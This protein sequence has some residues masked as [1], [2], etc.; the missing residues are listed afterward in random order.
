MILLIDNYDSFVHNLAR[1]FR[2]L[3]TTAHVVR[4]DAVDLPTIRKLQPHAIV[5]SPGPCTPTQA[6]CSLEVVRELGGEVPILGVCLGHQAIGAA[7]GGKIVP[8]PEPM[9]GRTS[10]IEHD[11][12]GLFAG[13]PSPLNVGRYHSLVIEPG[14]LPKQLEVT[15]RTVDGVIMAV[16]HRVLPIWGVQFHPESILTE[17]GYALLA[18]FLRMAGIEPALLAAKTDEHPPA[19]IE[20]VLPSRPVTF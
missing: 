3:G 13:L 20:Y 5:L 8:A 7:L 17:G 10:L 12:A 16:A 2:R 4:N 15:A 11:G 18:N 19:A 1:H 6:G 9:H 14:T